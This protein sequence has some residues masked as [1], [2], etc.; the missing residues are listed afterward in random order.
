MQGLAFGLSHHLE[1]VQISATHLESNLPKFS[2]TTPFLQHWLP[3]ATNIQFNTLGA[4]LRGSERH[5]SLL[6]PNHV[7][8][9]LS[10][11]TTAFLC[12][13][14]IGRTTNQRTLWSSSCSIPILSVNTAEC[15]GS[16]L[17]CFA[18]SV[19]LSPY[20]TAAE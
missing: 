10:V 16:G 2:H 13:W 18:K 20:Q 17:F 8:T 15:S 4:N 19:H 3:V 7:Q 5:C 6:P 12:L 9:L 11:V 1:Q 14:V